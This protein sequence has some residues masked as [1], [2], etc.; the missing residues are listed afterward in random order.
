[1][2]T[3]QGFWS[4]VHADDQAEGERI[5]R[6]ARD[7]AAQFEMLT[8]EPLALFLDRD[9]IRWGEDWRDRIDSSLSS[10]AFF[11]P[12]MTPRYFMSPECRRELQFFARQASRLGIK[13][14]VLPLLYVDVPALRND[15]TGD[16]LMALVRTFQWE[17][18]R[19]LRFVDPAAEAYRRGVA[20][21]SARLVE[22]NKQA[23]RT[24]VAAIAL[25]MEQPTQG[26]AEED[27][28]GFLDRVATAEDTLPKLKATMEA[29][30]R[31]IE[32]I[33]QAM[34][35]ATVDVQQGNRQA[36]G[37]AARLLVA[38]RVARQLA[39]PA[40]RVWS[41]GND[42]ASQ[43]HEIDVGVRA[44]IEHA[45]AEVR[46]NPESRTAVCTFFNAVRSLSGGAHVGLG[47]AQGMIDAIAPIE[48]MSRDLR[49][50][51]RRL[52]QGLA[53]MVEAREISDEWVQLIDG[54]DVTC[55]D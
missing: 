20:R 1:M 25:E 8:G 40:E 33:G 49:P 6:L 16:D 46:Q 38:R 39:E 32:L 52:R 14:L 41:L 15:E 11:V 47:H 19:D 10:I 2:A 3:S 35:Q 34:Q 23:E 27:S 17:D 42:F 44:I 50:V 48:N 12:V 53:T 30:G 29:I 43:L 24:D 51:L 9:A 21:L 28:P 13:E 7:V 5:S 45:V 4:Y 26:N 31:D 36:Q 37:F 18:W 54:S 55:E 22:A